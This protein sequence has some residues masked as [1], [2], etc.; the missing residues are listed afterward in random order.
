MLQEGLGD[1]MR[2][3]GWVDE[4]IRVSPGAIAS[5]ESIE[6]NCRQVGEH[7]ESI[8][9]WAHLAADTVMPVYW[10]FHHWDA[11]APG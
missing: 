10:D 9:D 6:S 7:V 3:Q 2:L 5:A 8:P 1:G 4:A 11:G